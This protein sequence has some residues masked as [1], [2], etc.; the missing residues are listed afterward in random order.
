MN[1]D[2]RLKELE[3]RLGSED[4]IY[5]VIWVLPPQK[6]RIAYER[7]GKI[8]GDFTILKLKG[9]YNVE[10]STGEIRGILLNK[11]YENLSKPVIKTINQWRRDF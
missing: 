4:N 3:K 9:G 8:Y 2:G 11:G 6:K 7:D 10:V 1:I 5:Y